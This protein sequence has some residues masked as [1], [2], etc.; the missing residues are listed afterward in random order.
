LGELEEDVGGKIDPEGSIVALQGGSLGVRGSRAE[1]VL[2][3]VV[4]SLGCVYCAWVGLTLS[5]HSGSFHMMFEGLGVEL[6]TAT[7][8]LVAHG[9]ILLPAMFGAL[10][11]LLVVKEAL[12]KDKRVSAILTCLITL[13]AQIAAHTII[14]VYYL[15][16]FELTRKLS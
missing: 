16:L 3:W 6:P 9:T 5:W 11:L 12:L 10:I 13:V 4:N 7:R 14:T 15:P 1:T 2:A 8:L